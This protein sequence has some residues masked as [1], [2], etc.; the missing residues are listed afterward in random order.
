MFRIV[1]ALA[2]PSSTSAAKG[3]EEIAEQAETEPIARDLVEEVLH[4]LTGR[5]AEVWS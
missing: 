5:Y 1:S 2:H 3:A 4:V